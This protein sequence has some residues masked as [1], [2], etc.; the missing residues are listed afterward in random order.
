[1]QGLSEECHHAFPMYP[2]VDDA[3]FIRWPT[4][5][6]R[7]GTHKLSTHFRHLGWQNHLHSHAMHGVLFSAH[8]YVPKFDHVPG[9]L[10]ADLTL[11]RQ[12]LPQRVA[13]LSSSVISKRKESLSAAFSSSIAASLVVAVVGALAP[14]R[15][16][17]SISPSC[18]TGAVA[19]EKQ[20]AIRWRP[21]C[22]AQ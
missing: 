3:P 1:M 4:F 5:D 14:E 7:R 20:M 16:L 2:N 12:D 21:R 9:R 17:E 6:I 22:S 13:E 11:V 18:A 19:S 15:R 8:K 10:L